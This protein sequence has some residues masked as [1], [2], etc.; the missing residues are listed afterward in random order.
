MS[1]Y[2]CMYILLLGLP[3]HISLSRAP[4]LSRNK[5]FRN[6]YTIPLFIHYPNEVI[7]FTYDYLDLNTE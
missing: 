6:R 4:D 3:R 1:T 7:V 2:L 5:H